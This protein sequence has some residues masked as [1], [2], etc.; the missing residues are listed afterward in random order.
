MQPFYLFFILKYNKKDSIGFLELGCVAQTLN[1]TM[2][3]PIDKRD[4]YFRNHFLT[5]CFLFIY[6][7]CNAQNCYDI[8]FETGTLNG[9]TTTGNVALMSAG[10]DIYGNF[11]VS[12][13]GGNYSVKL[14][15]NTDPTPST[16]SRSFVVTSNAPILT[17]RYA[18]DILN[19]P[20]TTPDAGRV[21]IDIFDNTNTVIPCAHYEGFFSTSGGPQG[22][23]IS[24]QPQEGNIGGE[25]CYDISYKPWTSLSVDLTPYIGQTVTLKAS[26][27]WCIY[28][29]DWAYAYFDFGCTNYQIDQDT[30]CNSVGALLIAPEDFQTYSWLGP[31]VVTGQNNDSAYVNQ[32]G[33]Y[34]VNMTTATGC[35]ISKTITVTNVPAVVNASVS[36][37]TEICLGDNVTLS[38]TGGLTYLWWN[39]SV[40]TPALTVSP[41]TTTTYIVE[42]KDVHGCTDTAS[43]TIV[44][45]PS[46]ISD[47]S[48]NDVCLNQ[49]INFTNLSSVPSGTITAWSWDFG[50]TS[51]FVFIQSPSHFYASVGSYPTSLIVTTNKGCKDTLVKN[52]I[53]HP[54]PDAQ[55]STANVCMGSIVPFTDLSMLSG[56]DI[57]QIWSWNYGDGSP[58]NNN[59]NSLHLY[60]TTG[61]YT[62]KL[63]VS[64]NFGCKDSIT[65]VVTINPNPVVNFTAPDTV[66]CNP[67]CVDFQSLASITGGNNASYLWNFGDGSTS[68]VASDVQHCY[69][70]NSIF[71]PVTFDVSLTVT[72]DSGCVAFL[73]KNN[74]IIVNPNPIANFTA[75]PDITSIVDPVITFTNLSS[76]ENGWDWNFGD[77]ATSFVE[78]PL[79]HTYADSGK[80]IITLI[81][82]NQ[83]ACFDTTYRTITIEPDWAF[84]VPNVF[85]P[86]GDGTNDYF[87]GYGFGLLDYE[88]MIFD[89]WGDKIFLTKDYYYPWDGRANKGDHVAQQDVYVYLIK[90]KDIKSVEHSYRGIVTLIK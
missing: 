14:G 11:P 53:V 70:N 63:I 24:S 17:Y 30:T 38:A 41:I 23:I 64:S 80:Y 22:F 16:I 52:V 15:N 81:V 26:C 88:M 5:A 1:Y 39:T 66:G 6:A 85:S 10:T 29:V 28:D 36:G 9:W 86:N 43:A 76:G 67:L 83:Y 84:F 75:E 33:T 2:K 54:L 31:G 34:T 13:P 35:N 4:S 61:N 69:S 12:S 40:T 19:Y 82:S 42:V 3:K 78:N 55:F 87:Q 72:S 21:V 71:S 68:G 50:D 48:P 77:L 73:S 20:H 74:Y 89:R 65:K 8:D 60:A 59:Q 25:C 79:P 44:L 45:N 56:T 58:V 90:I 37:G 49:A 32:T 27:K 57:L 51:P 47:F 62:S 18:M 7:V 46:P